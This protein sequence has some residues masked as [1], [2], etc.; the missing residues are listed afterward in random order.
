MAVLVQPPTM[1]KPLTGGPVIFLGGPIQGAPDWQRQAFDLLDKEGPE[2]LVVANPRR[3]TLGPDFNYDEQVDW[4]SHWLYKAGTGRGHG[5]ILFWFAA[6]IEEHPERVYA[7]TSRFELGEWFGRA[8]FVR[9]EP[10]DAPLPHTRQGSCRP[11]SC[12]S[13]HQGRLEPMGRSLRMIPARRS[14]ADPD[15]SR[16][17]LL[18]A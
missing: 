10:G 13:E 9:S 1:E 8:Q 14:G 4:E 5:V 2:S 16:P 3:D 11:P 6:Q 7:Q 12:R 18:P 15:A 17:S